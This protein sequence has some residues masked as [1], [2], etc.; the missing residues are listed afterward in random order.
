[1]GLPWVRLDTDIANHDK[2]VKLLGAKDGWRAFT[3]YICALG[4]SGGH[5]K[6]GHVPEHILTR[7]YGQPRHARMLVDHGLWTYDEDGDGWWIRNYDSRQELAVVSE[8]KRA[9]QRLGGLKS[10][11]RK[12]HG[13]DCNCWQKG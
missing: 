5:G 13:P 10:A 9:A 4:W 6:D 7:L 11:C 1:M 12:H 3:V 8:A 2:V